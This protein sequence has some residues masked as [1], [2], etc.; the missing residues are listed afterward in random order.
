MRWPDKQKPN[1]DRES[2]IKD[3]Y[4]IIGSIAT[5][6]AL[7]LSTGY[8]T[9]LAKKL[10]I[11]FTMSEAC[12]FRDEKRRQE[13]YAKY[14]K[15]LDFNNPISIYLLGYLWA[16]GYISSKTGIVT[17]QLARKDEEIGKYFTEIGPWK[18]KLFNHK[19]N[20]KV[21]PACKFSACS[22]VLAAKLNELNYGN[23]SY[24]DLDLVLDKIPI[25]KQNLFF[26][27]YFD[28]DGCLSF[29]KIGAYKYTITMNQS[30]A[31]KTIVKFFKKMSLKP[32]V[33]KQESKR[34]H[35]SKTI[36]FFRKLEVRKLLDWIYTGNTEI[37]LE[38]KYQKY[39]EMTNH[40]DNINYTLT[41]PKSLKVIVNGKPYNSL[42]EASRM[43][44]ID[45][46]KLKASA[47]I[48]DGVLS[49][50]EVP[51]SFKQAMVA[52]EEENFSER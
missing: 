33:L 25:D 32:V 6:K 2:F 16:D 52:L 27:G 48:I 8:V 40:I 24:S 12:L 49:V 35:L 45:R 39:L 47:K 5:A 29:Q 15:L 34:G 19:L 46:F 28:G 38:R 31:H 1:I 13:Q 22:I 4:R 41:N 9:I 37:C 30:A 3:N 26:R 50:N 23:K 20:G 7:G 42:R 17:M 43:T 44:G 18:I 10:G 11:A 14:A 21:Y 51:E 36:N